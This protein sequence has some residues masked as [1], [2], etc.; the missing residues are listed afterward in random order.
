MNQT[1]CAQRTSDIGSPDVDVT[2]YLILS[3]ASFLH[4]WNTSL[5]RQPSKTSLNH[6]SY[7]MNLRFGLSAI[8]LE[9]ER[10][11]YLERLDGD[12]DGLASASL[13]HG[14]V[15]VS[16]LSAAQLVPHRDVGALDLPFVRLCRRPRH[17]P[18]RLTV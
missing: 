8:Q 18:V 10:R 17:Q 14:F 2:L 13:P 15:D 4:M 6:R 3:S 11:A 5:T 16:V 7:I 12:R 9:P 1:Y